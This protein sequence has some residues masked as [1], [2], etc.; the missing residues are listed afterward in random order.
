M[1]AFG[2][3]NLDDEEFCVMAYLV[4][5]GASVLSLVSVGR[6]PGIIFSFDVD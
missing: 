2:V 3:Y 5:Y 4:L 1:E 6:G